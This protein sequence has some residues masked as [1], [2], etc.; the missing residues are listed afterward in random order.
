MF[1]CVCVDADRK[2]I[3]VFCQHP[4]ADMP[5]RLTVY[6][7]DIHYIICGHKRVLSQLL[8]SERDLCTSVIPLT[9]QQ[10]TQ[11]QETAI[12]TLPF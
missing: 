5:E 9:A 4:Q 2:Q 6:V 10:R 3:C 7:K 1:V 12:L 11:N 8:T